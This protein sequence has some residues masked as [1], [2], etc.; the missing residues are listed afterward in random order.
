MAP[1][2][3]SDV[4]LTFEPQHSIR[5]H[6]KLRL[7]ATIVPVLAAWLIFLSGPSGLWAPLLESSAPQPEAPP[8]KRLVAKAQVIQAITKIIKPTAQLDRN[9]R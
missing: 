4:S 8:V 1:P 9:H 6:R 7:S 3:K 2:E 5:P